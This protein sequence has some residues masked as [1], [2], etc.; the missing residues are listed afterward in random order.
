MIPSW[1]TIEQAPVLSEGCI[2][3][4][5]LY[6]DD[7]IASCIP[8]CTLDPVSK[9]SVEDYCGLHTRDTRGKDGR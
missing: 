8:C 7:S 5:V 3:T 9:T 6:R 2:D 1:D 4:D